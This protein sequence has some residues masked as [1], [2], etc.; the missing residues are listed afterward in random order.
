[1]KLYN[2]KQLFYS[3]FILALTTTLAETV[4][5]LIETSK[6]NGFITI[7]FIL[8]AVVVILI[9]DYAEKNALIMANP[10]KVLRFAVLNSF[11]TFIKA[12]NFMLKMKK[13]S[14]NEDEIV[15]DINAI[16]RHLL[17]IGEYKVRFLLGKLIYK[18]SK[19]TLYRL[20]A[21]IDEI[22]WTSVMMGKK[23]ICRLF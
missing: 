12:Y 17:L 20:S 22:G 1:M 23:K 5:S 13:W 21:L 15:K 3:L 6:Y 8:I 10:K 18:N 16:S 7:G 14:T 2:S 11:Q 4:K 9:L 19:N